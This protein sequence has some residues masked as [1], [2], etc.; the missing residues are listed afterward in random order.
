MVGAAGAGCWTERREGR[1]PLRLL[2]RGWRQ[3]QQRGEERAA[4][5]QQRRE[6]GAWGGGSGSSVGR[7]ERADLSGRGRGGG[8]LRR[9]ED[10][11]GGGLRLEDRVCGVGSH[12]YIMN[13]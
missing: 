6:E 2:I 12:F 9:G 10:C 7:R 1:G 4:G 5:W 3:R 11:D 8:V 13:L